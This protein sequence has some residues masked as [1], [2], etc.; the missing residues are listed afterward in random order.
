MFTFR[1]S[2]VTVDLDTLA[3]GGALFG[4]GLRP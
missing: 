4:V 3:L 1:D 2:P